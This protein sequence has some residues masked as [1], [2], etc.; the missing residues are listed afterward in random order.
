MIIKALNKLF[1]NNNLPARY[2]I[3]SFAMLGALRAQLVDVLQHGL[4][5]DEYFDSNVNVRGFKVIVDLADLANGAL[6]GIFISAFIIFYAIFLDSELKVR[7]QLFATQSK[8]RLEIRELE[9]SIENFHSNAEKSI[10]LRT[11]E[12]FDIRSLILEMKRKRAE[13]NP[14]FD[15]SFKIAG[16]LRESSSELV[17]NERAIY[18]FRS[19]EKIRYFING[20]NLILKPTWFAVTSLLITLGNNISINSPTPLFTILNSILCWALLFLMNCCVGKRL[21]KINSNFYMLLIVSVSLSLSSEILGYLLHHSLPLFIR[22][23]RFLFFFVL[24]AAISFIYNLLNSREDFRESRLFTD[25]LREKYS[26]L[27]SVLLQTQREIAEHLHGY[28]V[29]RVSEI[30]NRFADGQVTENEIDDLVFEV[31]NDFSYENYSLLSR[32]FTLNESSLNRLSVEWEGLM[33]IRFNGDLGQVDVIPNIQKREVWNVIIE[34][35]NNAHR[36]GHAS[37]IAFNLDLNKAGFLN[38]TAINDGQHTPLNSTR[39]TG[40]SIIEVASD[41]NWSIQNLEPYGV[42]VEV[43]IEFYETEKKDL[44][45]RKKIESNKWG[46]NRRFV[47]G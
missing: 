6:I 29:F 31:Q 42:W 7:Q 40:S 25:E 27:E 8:L 39:G 46:G 23:Q 18:P 37:E 19:F 3:F 12:K 35:I 34:L 24:L 43:K 1:P 14:E 33:K 15:L 20:T 45:K 13:S 2:I 47:N 17:R 26:Y 9:D 11:M 4:E 38:I 16:K 21:T 44:R 22:I 32:N 30:A 10:Y 36:H 28:L 5:G 41:G